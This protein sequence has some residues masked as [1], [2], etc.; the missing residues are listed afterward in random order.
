MR[1]NP[2]PADISRSNILKGVPTNAQLALTLLRIGEAN[3]A[4]L[5]PPPGSQEPP[6]NRAAHVDGSHLGATGADT[7][8]DASPEQ[9][10]AAIEPDASEAR[11]VTEANDADAGVKKTKKGS[12]FMAFFRGG[13]KATVT[14]SLGANKLRAKVVGSEHAKR[15]LGVIPRPSDVLTSGPSEFKARFEGKKGTAYVSAGEG[16]DEGPMLSF[17]MED[18]TLSSALKR[19]TGAV[20]EPAWSIS[21]GDIRELKKAG[22]LGWKAK[23]IVGWALEKPVADGLEIVDRHG[24]SWIV[25]AVPLRDELFN[26]LIAM[27]GQKWEA[28]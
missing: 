18:S 8:L 28:W 14:T 21:V 2:R 7:A 24:R 9:L 16:A 15:R 23:L 19:D 27:G 4:P 26:R 6:P 11:E 17:V 3:K 13:A 12:A 10:R 1:Q 22:G 5:P 25:T 20:R